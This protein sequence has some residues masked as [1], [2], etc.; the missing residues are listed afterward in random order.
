MYIHIS[1]NK[2]AKGKK[3]KKT[4]NIAGNNN[5]NIVRI[6]FTVT[7]GLPFSTFKSNALQLAL[8]VAKFNKA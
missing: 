1:K 4:M 8:P 3:K 5:A 6:S 2:G 7:F